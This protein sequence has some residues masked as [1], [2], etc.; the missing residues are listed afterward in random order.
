MPYEYLLVKRNEG[1]AAIILNQPEK[2]KALFQGLFA[3]L[4]NVPPVNHSD[5]MKRSPSCLS[6]VFSEMVGERQ[7]ATGGKHGAS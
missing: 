4:R 3:E 7:H 2:H 6:S 5:S 1:V